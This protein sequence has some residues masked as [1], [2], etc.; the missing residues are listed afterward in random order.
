MDIRSSLTEA[1]WV[2][3]K[4]GAG[5][6]AYR[7][8]GQQVRAALRRPDRFPSLPNPYAGIACRAGTCNGVSWLWSGDET[9][10]LKLWQ[11]VAIGMPESHPMD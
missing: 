7:F 9:L 10:V 8:A 1:L 11:K 3:S 5:E 2:G 4:S 6:V